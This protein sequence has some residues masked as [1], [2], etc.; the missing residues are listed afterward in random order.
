[1][2]RLPELNTTG[3]TDW[4]T[5]IN[6]PGASDAKVAE[7]IR[8]LVEHRLEDCNPNALEPGTDR[9]P[10]MLAAQKGWDATTRAILAHPDCNP[11]LLDKANCNSALVWAV[12]VLSVPCVQAISMDPRTRFKTVNGYGCYNLGPGR[13]R[14]VC[15][16]ETY[17]NWRAEPE[18]FGEGECDIDVLPVTPYAAFPTAPGSQEKSELASIAAITVILREARAAKPRSPTFNPR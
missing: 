16:F 13:E 6:T 5:L 17:L 18:F 15:D 2:S 11:N 7:L 4:I 10:L 14:T 12:Q 3:T 1:M 9:T 8:F